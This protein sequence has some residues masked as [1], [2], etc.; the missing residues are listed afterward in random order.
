M[1]GCHAKAIG[2]ATITLGHTYGPGICDEMVT[3]RAFLLLAFVIAR[4]CA[5]WC[6]DV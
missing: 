2:P 6:Y 3:I 4:P 5:M 1:S